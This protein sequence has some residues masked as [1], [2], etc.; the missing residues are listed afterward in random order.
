MK[1]LIRIAA[2]NGEYVVWEE[3]ARDGAQAK[4]LIPA[5]KRVEVA[6]MMAK[7]FNGNGSRNVIFCAGFPAVHKLEYE[8]TRQVAMEVDTLSVTCLCRSVPKDIDTAFKAMRGSTYG[9]IFMFV[10]MSEATAQALMKKSAPEAMKKGLEAFDYAM[11]IADGMPVDIALVDVAKAD[12]GLLIEAADRAH[13]NGAATVMLADTT[14]QMY[15]HE[16]FELFSDVKNQTNEDIVYVSHMHNDLGFGLI[17][18]MEA[19]RAGAFVGSSSFLG[20]GERTGMPHTE[21]LIFNF[22]QYPEKLKAMGIKGNPWQNPV[23]LKYLPKITK[24]ISETTKI[25]IPITKPIVGLGVHTI[26]TET[27]FKDSNAFSPFNAKEILG[28]EHE[29]VLTHLGH[30]KVI[31]HFANEMGLTIPEEM[32]ESVIDW[33]KTTAYRQGS[34]EIC[35]DQFRAY[36]EGRLAAVEVC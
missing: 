34:A 36:V 35:P 4:T 28:L 32:L 3:F 29:V 19:V 7:M 25:P 27:P 30:F 24:I 23:D 31:Q 2:Q 1:D 5:N 12:R 8:A 9:R 16:V 22:D 14:G 10:P 17:N 26:S 15:P 21:E 18:T 11:Q 13:E 6:H 20:Y 33:V